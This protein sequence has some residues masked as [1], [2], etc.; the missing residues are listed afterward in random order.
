[1]VLL[2]IGKPAH[3]LREQVFNGLVGDGT[4]SAQVA[5]SRRN[6]QLDVGQAHAVLAAVALFFHQEVHLVQA[7]KGRPIMVDV[8]LQWLFEP[9]KGYATLVL[10]KVAHRVPG[11]FRSCEFRAAVRESVEIPEIDETLGRSDASFFG[12]PGFP[13]VSFA[14][15][16]GRYGSHVAQLGEYNTQ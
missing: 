9:E 6:R 15:N 11:R 2:G 4:R 16:V 1:M 12:R 10:E 5:V 7:V 14:R 3:D 13:A 8:I